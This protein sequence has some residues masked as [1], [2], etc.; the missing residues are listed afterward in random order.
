[1]P[2]R[3]W[4][5]N[6]DTCDG[7]R[8]WIGYDL[9]DL[10]VRTLLKSD[11]AI[12]VKVTSSEIPIPFVMSCVYARNEEVDRARLWNSLTTIGVAASSHP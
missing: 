3:N 7:G 5:F 2:F 1:M 4:D 11:Q 8:I 6:Y 10:S 12:H 9:N